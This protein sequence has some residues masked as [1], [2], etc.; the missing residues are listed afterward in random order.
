MYSSLSNFCSKQVHNLNHGLRTLE[1]SIQTPTNNIN[2]A[3][4]TQV[5][6]RKF[7]K[8]KQHFYYMQNLYIRWK[9]NQDNYILGWEAF[10]RWKPEG[11]VWFPGQISLR[12]SMERKREG[13]DRV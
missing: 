1:S 9:I 3:P 8:R 10:S 6:E 12:T 5:Q 7:E 2:Q 4:I 11:V 13:E